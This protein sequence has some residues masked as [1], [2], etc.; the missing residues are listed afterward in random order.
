MRRLIISRYLHHVVALVTLMAMLTPLVIPMCAT[1]AEAPAAMPCHP[2]PPGDMPCHADDAAPDAATLDCCALFVGE[3]HDE[4]LV[5]ADRYDV[6]LL[7]A[8]PV[9]LF[10]DAASRPGLPQE[11][12]RPDPS[13]PRASVGIPIL[14]RSLLN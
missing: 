3:L 1:A 4:G 13:P 7:L 2:P 12:A 8:L 10:F 5:P 6:P 14:L 9:F 11:I